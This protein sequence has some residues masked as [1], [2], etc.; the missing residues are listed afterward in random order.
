FDS[1]YK[2]NVEGVLTVNG[3]P[4]NGNRFVEGTQIVNVTDGKLTITNAA[5]AVNNKLDFVEIVKLPTPIKINFQP[6]AA[7][8]PAG[9]L[10]DAGLTYANRGNGQS[11]GWNQSITA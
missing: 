4:T 2:V 9:Y 1:T 7:P 3:K 8:V 5:G 6:N 11:Y 10:K